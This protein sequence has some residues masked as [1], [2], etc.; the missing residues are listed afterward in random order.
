MKK[1]FEI[2]EQLQADKNGYLWL[3]S[4]WYFLST[5]VGDEVYIQFDRCKFIDANLSSVMGALFDEWS[6]K[7]VRVFLTEP[8]NRTVRKALSRNGFLSCFNIKN[9]I[10]EKE[11][12]IKYRCFDGSEAEAFKMYILDELLEK[13]K[14]PKCSDKAKEKIAE[15]IYE[16]FANAVTHSGK[17]AVY[18]CGES[19]EHNN[20]HML[21]MTIANLGRTIPDNVN[22]Y[23]RKQRKPELLQEDTIKWAFEKGNTTK[24]IP[25]GLG[26][27]ILKEFI[28][29]NHGS[30]QMLSGGS[31]LSYTNHIFTT[32]SLDVNFPGTIV[33][34]NFNC[35][36]QSAYSLIEEV[37]DLQDLL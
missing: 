27:D 23:L 7:G 29:L 33:T 36:D 8:L 4:L 5:A 22:E 32:D 3:V 26:L 12:Y 6:V 31:M 19:H 34:L 20:V 21:D 1:Y 37:V 13:Q 11:N 18:T 28:D 16:V 15:S 9:K 35:D 14:F 2:P 17:H 10:E 30:I 24:S 25:G